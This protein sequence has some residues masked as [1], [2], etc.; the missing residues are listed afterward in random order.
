MILP[1]TLEMTKVSLTYGVPTPEGR[2]LKL[3]RADLGDV[4]GQLAPYRLL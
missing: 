1:Q 2:T 4:M 3:A